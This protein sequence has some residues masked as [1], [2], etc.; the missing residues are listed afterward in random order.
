MSKAVK[1]DGF[2]TQ[3]LTKREEKTVKND[4]TTKETFGTTFRSRGRNK[5]PIISPISNLESPFSPKRYVST[6]IFVDTILEE[7]LLSRPNQTTV[8]YLAQHRS[9]SPCQTR[10]DPFRQQNL[11]DK[12]KVRSTST[13]AKHDTVLNFQQTG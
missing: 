7:K 2:C 8:N 11:R 13:F 5:N 6:R 4:W 10:K 1:I 12:H 9:L 3:L